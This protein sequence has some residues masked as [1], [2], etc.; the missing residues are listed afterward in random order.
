[1]EIAYSTFIEKLASY[2]DIEGTGYALFQ[3]AKLWQHCLLSLDVAE[4]AFCFKNNT[5]FSHFYM[6]ILVLWRI[7]YLTSKLVDNGTCNLNVMLSAMSFRKLCSSE[8][9][10]Q[11]LINDYITPIDTGGCC[12]HS[13]VSHC[14]T[15]A[16]VLALYSRGVLIWLFEVNRK[17]FPE[18]MPK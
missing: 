3:K 4:V 8:G 9:S 7:T 17:K 15:M 18:D 16:S 13:R 6:L 1:M 2:F 11:G 5:K 14:W 10:K 12:I